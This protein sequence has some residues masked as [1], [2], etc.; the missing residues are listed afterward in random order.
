MTADSGEDF[1]PADLVPWP[2]ARQVERL[3]LARFWPALAASVPPAAACI[4]AG[5][6]AGLDLAAFLEP[7]ARPRRLLVQQH[8]AAGLS[9]EAHAQ[10]QAISQRFPEVDVGAVALSP[11]RPWR[12]AVQGGGPLCVRVCS[13]GLGSLAPARRAALLARFAEAAGPGDVLI[14]TAM[15]PRDAAL[16]EAEA[17]ALLPAV[18]TQALAAL[19]LRGDTDA[20]LV[21]AAIHWDAGSGML[22]ADLAL[23]QA[24]RIGGTAL[25]AGARVPLLRMAALDGQ[26]LLRLAAGAGLP[27]IALEEDAVTGAAFIALGAPV[28]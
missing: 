22:C 17:A 19:R 2:G 18:A 11:D 10:L 27:V 23:R 3:A 14:A 28:R 24:G 16:M 9:A 20:D 6:W 13:G 5:P 12:D 21:R 15:A 26:A 4:D 7:V 1:L 8:G 25:P